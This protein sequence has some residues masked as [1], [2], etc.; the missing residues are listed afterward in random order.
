MG[1]HM[2]CLFEVLSSAYLDSSATLR[3]AAVATPE[4]A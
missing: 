2:Y 4:P 1:P 3:D